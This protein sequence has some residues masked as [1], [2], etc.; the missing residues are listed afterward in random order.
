MMTSSERLDRIPEYAGSWFPPAEHIVPCLGSADGSLIQFLSDQQYVVV[1]FLYLTP[2]GE[3]L[4]I[5]SVEGNIDA[6]QWEEL[7][8]GA[9]P[10][11]EQMEEVI[12]DAAICAPSFEAFIYRFWLESTLYSKLHGFDDR[13]LTDAERRYLAHYEP[14][15]GASARESAK[16][17]LEPW[18]V[19]V[20]REVH[21][22]PRAP[23]SG[24][25][26]TYANP[27][28]KGEHRQRYARSDSRRDAA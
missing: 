1:W 2:R 28:R 3:E 13:P 19:A 17:C 26:R 25:S 5:G 21:D 24:Q 22:P 9:G 7:H 14:A 18:I 12:A 11:A 6:A 20:R 23:R 4:V 10:N 8:D 15:P 27:L 16:V